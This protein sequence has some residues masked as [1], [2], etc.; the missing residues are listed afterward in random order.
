MAQAKGGG[1]KPDPL[2]SE[3]EAAASIGVK[4]RQLRDARYR[5]EV[6]FVKVAG[7]AMYRAGWLEAWIRRNTHHAK[8]RDRASSRLSEGVT[9]APFMS[10]ATGTASEPESVQ[11]AKR[12]M[13]KL[14]QSLKSGGR[15]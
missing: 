2:M 3:P 11:R 14:R 6:T 12:N 4:P 13:K 1:T 7:H 5:G 10:S 8:P 15:T 9:G